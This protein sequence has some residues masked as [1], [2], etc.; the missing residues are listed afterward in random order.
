[1]V[2]STLGLL[3]CLMSVLLLVRFSR[4]R[5]RRSSLMEVPLMYRTP[6]VSQQYTAGD[7][8]TQISDYSKPLAHTCSTNFVDTCDDP[9]TRA[10]DTW[11][12]RH[13]SQTHTL[14]SNKSQ[15]HRSHA[16]ESSYR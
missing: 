4:K 1:M 3:F 8:F 15:S 13:T 12:A 11:S 16:V 7:V 10:L 5:R 2:A 14:T 6:L 9:D